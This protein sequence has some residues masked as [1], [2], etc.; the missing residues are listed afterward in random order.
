MQ[1]NKIKAILITTLIATAPAF[2]QTLDDYSFSDNP[3]EDVLY[4]E[5][6]F[7][8]DV[9]TP[10]EEAAFKNLE[11]N[12]KQENDIQD[13]LTTEDIF[14]NDLSKDFFMP[15]EDEKPKEEKEVKKGDA[16]IE[17]IY[18]S[19]EEK[20]A[21]KNPY[22]AFLSMDNFRMI[23]LGSFATNCS[24]RFVIL[25]NFEENLNALDLRLTWP[26]IRTSL[27]FQNVIPNQSTYIEYTLMGEGCY[28]MSSV[29]NIEI[30]RCRS[31]GM[32]QEDCASTIRWLK[33]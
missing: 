21:D 2:A 15:T 5:E 17:R 31:K 29:P 13:D 7:I 24:M 22:V 18:S 33:K 20:E 25:T 19:E 26:E 16:T 14:N 8:E 6:N 11:A 23:K 30:N 4:Q 27:S 32:S 12:T 1:F 9:T 3:Q 28:S 10:Q